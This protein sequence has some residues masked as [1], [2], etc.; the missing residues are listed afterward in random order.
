M[1]LTGG[2]DKTSGM[3]RNGAELIGCR[4]SNY[5]LPC[6]ERL[7][8]DYVSGGLGFEDGFLFR[9]WVD[10]LAGL[11]SRFADHIHLHQTGHVEDARTPLAKTFADQCAKL[12]E[13]AGHIIFAQTRVVRQSGQDF[14]LGHR[15][16]WHLG[17][18]EGRFPT[19]QGFDESYGVPNSIDESVYSSLPDFAESGVSR[20]RET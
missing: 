17:R 16:K 5:V 1:I 14:G 4:R 11:G 2:V 20:T 10:T 19:D 6:P 18:T 8:L 13:N 9:E 3:T 12:V 15:L 7:N